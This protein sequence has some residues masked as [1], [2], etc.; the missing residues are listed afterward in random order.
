MP[1]QTII[2]PNC[3]KEIPLT[4]TLFHWAVCGLVKK[5]RKGKEY[6]RYAKGTG[7]GE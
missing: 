7:K 4:E 6:V 2:C 1:D 3:G 5:G